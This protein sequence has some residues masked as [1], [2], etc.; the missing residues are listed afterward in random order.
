[1]LAREVM[2]SVWRADHLTLGTEVAV[3]LI[4]PIIAQS[5]EAVPRFQQEAQSAAE[6]RERIESTTTIPGAPYQR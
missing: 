2:G 4:D 3:K 6:L 5:P 1:V